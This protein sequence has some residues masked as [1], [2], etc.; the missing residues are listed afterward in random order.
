[1]ALEVIGAGFGRTGTESMKLA[2]EA[3]GFGPCHHMS[4]VTAESGQRDAWR[5][6]AKGAAPDWDR[7]FAGYR[8]AVDWPAAFYWRALA[9]HYPQ[10]KVLLTLR[11]AESWYQSMCNTI[12]P[13]VET[14]EDRDSLGVSLV[15]EQVFDGRLRDRDHAIAVFERNTAEVQAA[16]PAERLLVFHLGDGWAPLCRFLGKPLPD[17]P[18]PRSNSTAE[19][20]AAMAKPR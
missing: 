1:M 2:L 5:A 12:I 13:V 15:A 8:A 7:I 16:I 19:F 10:A 17:G 6:L 18:F 11:S 4:E 20:Q 3:L 9:A 14:S